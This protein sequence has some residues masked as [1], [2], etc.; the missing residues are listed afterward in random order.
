MA[1]KITFFAHAT[2]FDNEL[3]ICSGQADA[4]ISNLGKERIKKLRKLTSSMNF[5]VVYCSDLSRS[6]ET[7]EGVFRDR[8][9]I[10]ID[11][12]L[13]ELNTGSF[14]GKPDK[15]VDAEML[16]H[17]NSPFPGGES[18]EDVKSRTVSFLSDLKKHHNS[19]IAIVAHMFNQISFEVILN[20]KSWKQALDDDWRKTDAW[21]P[22]WE[23]IIE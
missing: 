23:Y 5:Y 7:A 15:L 21:Q 6:R 20:K 3:G 17:I 4:K 8:L 16:N 9:E 12:R 13:R 19:Q 10:K 11:P 14:T 2:T 1:I 18:L 22:G